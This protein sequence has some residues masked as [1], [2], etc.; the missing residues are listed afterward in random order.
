MATAASPKTRGSKEG[1]RQHL[2]MIVHSKLK[3]IALQQCGICV[4]YC[5]ACTVGHQTSNTNITLACTCIHHEMH[6]HCPYPGCKKI[7]KQKGHCNT[8][9]ESCE[10]AEQ[11]RK[12]DMKATD[13][14]RP[15]KRRR[16]PRKQMSAYEFDGESCVQQAKAA[17]LINTGLF[18][19][20]TLAG[21]DVQ[22]ESAHH[23]RM[24]HPT[25]P[26]LET[27]PARGG[28][29]SAS[30]AH[31]MFHLTGTNRRW[32]TDPLSQ[33]AAPL[34]VYQA[35]AELQEPPPSSPPPGGFGCALSFA[36]H[37]K[38]QL[39][40]LT[41]RHLTSYEGGLSSGMEARKE[42]EG[43]KAGFLCAKT[44]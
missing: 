34:R 14:Q 2:P 18:K 12:S 8:H 9:M 42:R 16:R 13:G 41:T 32:S 22:F 31:S 37:P 43:G 10:F 28:A 27:P 29:N 30:A 7:Q 40:L 35:G 20:L 5:V 21:T 19:A 1:R 11:Y 3:A 24:L 33:P 17:T 39:P 36:G 44:Q 38:N 15:G 23:L 26:S 25:A 6:I 4:A